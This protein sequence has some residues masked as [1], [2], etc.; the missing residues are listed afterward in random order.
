MGQ[1]ARVASHV[2]GEV[3]TPRTTSRADHVITAAAMTL[4]GHQRMRWLETSIAVPEASTPARANVTA[5]ANAAAKPLTGRRWEASSPEMPPTTAPANARKRSCLIAG[6]RSTA[7]AVDRG[8]ELVHDDRGFEHER[9]A[10]RP[11]AQADRDGDGKGQAQPRGRFE[12]EG[13]GLGIGDRVARE[14]VRAAARWR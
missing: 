2:R 4:A 5:P 3:R 9:A 14:Q 12:G 8:V 6:P 13:D 10:S 11:G 1:K 7:A